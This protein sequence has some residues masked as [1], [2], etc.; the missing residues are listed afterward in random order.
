MAGWLTEQGLAECPRLGRRIEVEPGWERAVEAVLGGHLQALLT[1][2]PESHLDALRVVPVEGITLQG[3]VAAA[4]KTPAPN[5]LAT[6]VR[7]PLPVDDLLAGALRGT[8]S[9][10]GS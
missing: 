3:P 1:D 6:R 8:G 5:S 2:E 10:N 7:G 9:A 4:A